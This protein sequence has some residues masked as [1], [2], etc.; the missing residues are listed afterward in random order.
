ML[1]E[2]AEATLTLAGQLFS[3]EAIS[4]E[5]FAGDLARVSAWLEDG[6]RWVQGVCIMYHC[7]WVQGVCIIPMAMYHCMWVQGVCIM[8][9][10]RCLEHDR[11]HSMEAE[12]LTNLAKM[13]DTVADFQNFISFL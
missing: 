2:L 12:V 4:R 6:C 5:Q 7:R 3:K 11:A 13:R 1:H 10:C 9:D 8:Y